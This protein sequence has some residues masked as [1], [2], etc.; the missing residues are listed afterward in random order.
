MTPSSYCDDRY[1][2]KLAAH[3][4]RKSQVQFGRLRRKQ[5]RLDALAERERERE[6][7][8]LKFAR[9]AG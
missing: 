8:E 3:S 4:I 2:G 1:S 9:E 5:R 7:W 6:E